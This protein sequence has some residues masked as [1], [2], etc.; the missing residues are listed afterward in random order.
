[1]VALGEGAVSYERGTPV[2]VRT[3]PWAAGYDASEAVSLRD[4]R[5]EEGSYLRLIDVCTTQL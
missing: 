2:E 4:E 5:S 3:L 1:M